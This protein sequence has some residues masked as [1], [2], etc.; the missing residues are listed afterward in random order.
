MKSF[1]SMKQE[2]PP[3][4]ETGTFDELLTTYHLRQYDRKTQISTPVRHGRGV[5][6]PDYDEQLQAVFKEAG[7]G[8]F[9]RVDRDAADKFAVMG[10]DNDG[11]LP[12]C[13]RPHFDYLEETGEN[14]D[15]AS[16]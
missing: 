8:D 2:R 15:D 3:A 5:L 1:P 6:V 9:V 14:S 12:W 10:F 4:Y 7:D 13:P 11:P 16:V